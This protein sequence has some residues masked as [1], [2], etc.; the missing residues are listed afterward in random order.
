MARLYAIIRV[1]GQ[2]DVP[3]DVEHVLKLLRLHK[4]YHLTLYPADLPGLEGMLEKAKDWVTWGEID[5]ATLVKLLKTRGRVPGG[6]ALTN[7]YVAEKLA[8]YGVKDIEG[9][10]EALLEGKLLLHKLE[11]IVKPVFRMHPPR[12]GFDG[13]VKK[14]FKVKGELGYR[15]EKINEL[16]EKML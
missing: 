12:G 4:K 3:P 7:E 16:I 2:A 9:L 11:N 1:R 8:E 13:S 10:A 15:G 14:P 5:K 6:K